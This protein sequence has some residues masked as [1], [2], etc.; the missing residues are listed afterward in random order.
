MSSQIHKIH[1]QL[2]SKEITCTA[3][4]QEKL[5]L[6]KQNTHNTVNALLDTL[7]LDAL[8]LDTLSV[9][10]TSAPPKYHRLYQWLETHAFSCY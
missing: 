9:A 3:L 8:V 1:Q 2:M 5:D 4:V 7:A 6:L 10:I